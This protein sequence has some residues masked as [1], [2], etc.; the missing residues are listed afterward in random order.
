MKVG[1]R[2]REAGIP[3]APALR[4]FA[5]QVGD[6][7]YVC[8][9]TGGADHGAIGAAQAPRSDVVPAPML[10]VVV[11]EVLDVGRI[12][13][14]AHLR[15]GLGADGLGGSLFV[16]TRLGGRHIAEQ[17]GAA[18]AADLHNEVVAVAFQDLGQ[19]Q[20][21]TRR[22]LGASLHRHA[23]AGAAGLAAVDGNQESVFAP[24][25]I[26]R[27]HIRAVKKDTILYGDCMQFARADCQ[28]GVFRRPLALDRHLVAVA[29][30]LGLPEADHRR[31]QEFL[32][33]VRAHDVAEESL[34]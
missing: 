29:V 13:R 3:F 18:L 16:L 20:I 15:G 5:G 8:A 6:V 2:Q 1:K 30:A 14:T 10:V 24:R 28:E 27:V 23:K 17:V 21:K 4:M 7:F 26:H 34:V 33:R 25:L 11:K 31:M 12:Q 22:R 32:P 19:C 9:E